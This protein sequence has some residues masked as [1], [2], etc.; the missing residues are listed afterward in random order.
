MNEKIQ[1]I[2]QDLDKKVFELRMGL[3]ALQS[4]LGDAHTVSLNEQGVIVSPESETEPDGFHGKS[5]AA[6]LKEM[7]EDKKD[8]YCQCEEV[9]TYGMVCVTCDKPFQMKTIFTV[10][11]SAGVSGSE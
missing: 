10:N 5:Y 1:R 9:K 7:G 6:Y 8:Y 2:V 3:V 4:E 11:G